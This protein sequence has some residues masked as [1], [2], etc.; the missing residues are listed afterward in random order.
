[1]FSKRPSSPVHLNLIARLCLLLLAATGLSGTGSSAA[2]AQFSSSYE[3]LKAVRESDGATAMRI[4]LQPGLA[5]V[6]RLDPGSGEAP[7]HVVVKRKDL[8]WLGLLLQH[9][10]NVNNPDSAGNTPLILAAGNGFTDGADLLIKLGAQVN[11]ANRGGETALI[12]AV[13]ARDE[14][15]VRLLLNKGA[16]PRQADAVIGY[17]AIDYARR[18]NRARTILALLER[19]DEAEEE[20]ASAPAK[21]SPL[22]SGPIQILG[23]VPPAS[24]G[25]AAPAGPQ[26]P[27]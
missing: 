1:M 14:R 26:R 13:Q 10:A 16:D 9:R 21:D 4:L 20:G 17:S 2:L 3:L 27:N 19:G 18:D 6:D 25:P 11:G 15:M 24:P 22:P 23:P 12:K 8:P 5:I 7:I